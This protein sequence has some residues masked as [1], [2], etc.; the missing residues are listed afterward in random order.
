[1]GPEQ[2]IAHTNTYWSTYW[3]WAAAAGRKGDIVATARPD[4][5]T[6]R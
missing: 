4:F 6:S 3:S 2:V 1:M 5:P